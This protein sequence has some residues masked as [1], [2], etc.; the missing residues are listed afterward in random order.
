MEIKNTNTINNIKVTV[1]YDTQEDFE[2]V[3]A[4]N[5]LNETRN[6]FMNA[7]KFYTPKI[8]AMG[9]AK[10]FAICE[11]LKPLLAIMREAKI[12]IIRTKYTA[13]NTATQYLISITPNTERMYFMGG[14][15]TN[16]NLSITSPAFSPNNSLQAFGIKKAGFITRWEEY[17]IYTNLRNDLLR[18]IEEKTEKMQSKTKD[19]IDH[20]AD[21]RDHN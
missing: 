4:L 13:D 1:E 12:D 19:L 10:W 9:E 18:K 6:A 11:Q 20:F 7:D 15:W 16:E 8:N 2:L 21:V 14:G 3:T 17:N 5:K